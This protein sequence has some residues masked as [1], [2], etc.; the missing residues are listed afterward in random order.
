MRLIPSDFSSLTQTIASLLEA[1]PDG[2]A[3]RAGRSLRQRQN[4]AGGTAGRTVSGQRRLPYRRL[5]SSPGT[6]LP[7]WA[8]IALR[9]MDLTRLREEVL[10]PAQAGAA[11][12][13]RAYSCREGSYLPEQCVPPHRSIYWRAATATTRSL[14][15]FMTSKCSSPVPKKNRPAVCRRGKA[16]ATKT[17][18]V[19][20]FLWK[21]PTLRVP[22]RS[23]G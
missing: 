23:A 1:H 6:A 18:S 13:S 22:H 15:A 8:E 5:L 19:G 14:Q 16:N 20:G 7:N 10:V 2:R 4:D 3:H 11:V 21:R 9:H 17:L 12:R